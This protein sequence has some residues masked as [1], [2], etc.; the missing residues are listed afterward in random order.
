MKLKKIIQ[1]TLL[2]V[3]FALLT[4]TVS[5]ANQIN[6]NQEEQS[7][8]IADIDIDKD[9]LSGI[10]ET[11]GY[12][13]RIVGGKII[14]AVQYIC[15]GAAIIILIYKGVQFMIKAPEAKAELKK[16]LVSYVIGAVILFSVGTI[17]KLIGRIALNNLF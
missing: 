4:S 5:K 7:I 8:K 6:Y 11:Q 2:I 15:Y 14:G 16:E 10:Y 3:S 12:T 1:I 17:I 9:K 13:Y